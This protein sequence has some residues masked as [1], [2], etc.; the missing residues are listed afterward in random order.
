MGIFDRDKFGIQQRHRRLF[1]GQEAYHVKDVDTDQE[2]L[3]IKRDRFGRKT[4][5]HV[6]PGDPKSTPEIIT[7]KDLSSFDL[8]ASFD[9]LDNETNQN[10]GRAKRNFWSSLIRENWTI[11]DGSG[12]VIGKVKARS[13]LKCIL[14]NPRWIPI[15]GGI[16]EL[17]SWLIRLQFDIYLIQNGE[18]VKV[19]E[20]NRKRTIGDK[21]ILD[22]TTDTERRFNRKF[23]VA[24]AILLDSAEQR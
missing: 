15:I 1:S 23:A 19:G 10:L 8:W 3:W 12:N 5:M 11:W 18:E 13:L 22:L 7:I 17:F 2:L 6:F 14:R 4:H 9:V 21:Y 24:L 20:F 16:F